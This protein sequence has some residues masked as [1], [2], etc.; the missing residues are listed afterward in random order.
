M[1]RIAADRELAVTKVEEGTTARPVEGATR[2]GA[3]A[4]AVAEKRAQRAALGIFI[5]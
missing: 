4:P 2:L 3:K 5:V 1:R